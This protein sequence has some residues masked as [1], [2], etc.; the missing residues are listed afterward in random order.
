MSAF[1][2]DGREVAF[3]PGDSIAAALMRSGTLTFRHSRSGEP[4]GLYC[5][6]G[7]CNDCLVSVD[8]RPNVR[9]CI[10]P[11]KAGTRVETGIAG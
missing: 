6:I 10:A 5:G 8:G 7:V 4:R 1:T 2:V 9:A 11:A 3:Q